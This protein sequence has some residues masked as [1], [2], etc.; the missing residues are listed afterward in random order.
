MAWSPTSP[1]DDERLASLR[2]GLLQL[3]PNLEQEDLRFG[4]ARTW[5]RIRARCSPR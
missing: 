2:Q 3:S 5:P 4:Y 1:L